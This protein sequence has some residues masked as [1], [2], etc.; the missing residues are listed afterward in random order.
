MTAKKT[1]QLRATDRKILRS[2]RDGGIDT[3]VNIAALTG[4][5]LSI[6]AQSMR[7]LIVKGYI[8]KSDTQ[9]HVTAKGR[10]MA[11]SLHRLWLKRRESR[12]DQS[13][14]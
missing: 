9:Y 4:V 2:F 1:K 14:G 6:V 7:L 5:R 13:G 11:D 3:Q 12:R 8:T 10:V